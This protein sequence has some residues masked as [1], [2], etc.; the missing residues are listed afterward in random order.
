MPALLCRK[1][2]GAAARVRE[3]S[4]SGCGFRS[5]CVKRRSR[6]VGRV[7][8]TSAWR[9]TVPRS[10][11]APRQRPGIRHRPRVGARGQELRAGWGGRVRVR[12][13]GADPGAPLAPTPA[14]AAPA[15]PVAR[16]PPPQPGGTFLDGHR[17]EPNKPTSVKPGARLAFGSAGA[18]PFTFDGEAGGTKRGR[19]MSGDAVAPPLRSGTVR[20]SHLLVK[21]RDSRRP[22]SWKEERVTRTRVS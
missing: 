10:A 4:A 11:R 14:R 16:R 6:G 22:A 15:T 1:G 18:R 19:E 21:H 2:S 7:L 9:R 13:C 20:A 12:V 3:V 17:L 8:A 5:D